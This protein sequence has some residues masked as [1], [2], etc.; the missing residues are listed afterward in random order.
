MLDCYWLVERIR[1]DTRDS[2]SH[3][4]WTSEAQP[5]IGYDESL[6]TSAASSAPDEHDDRP[7]VNRAAAFCGRSRGLTVD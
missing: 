6:A 4:P 1:S 7:S 5:C 2:D 3:V